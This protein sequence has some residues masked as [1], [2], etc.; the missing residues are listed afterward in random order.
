MR[1]EQLVLSE[2]RRGASAPSHGVDS[3]LVDLCWKEPMAKPV[4]A[5]KRRSFSG[6]GW[7]G[8]RASVGC[9]GYLPRALPPPAYQGRVTRIDASHYATKSFRQRTP[10]EHAAQRNRGARSDYR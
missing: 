5:A 6:W 3:I 9:E 1:R 7:K 4:E 2:E 8:K 10:P